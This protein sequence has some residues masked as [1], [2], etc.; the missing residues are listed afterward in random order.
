MN[1]LVCINNKL[2][3]LYSEYVSE[4]LIDEIN[5]HNIGKIFKF[6]SINIKSNLNNDIVVLFLIN[7]NKYSVS[8]SVLGHSF[9][10][11]F[12][13]KPFEIATSINEALNN[14]TIT[15]LCESGEIT[16]IFYDIVFHTMIA[17]SIKLFY[18]EHHKRITSISPTG[19]RIVENGFDIGFVTEC[20]CEGQKATLITYHDKITLNVDYNSE[21]GH[22]RT[23]C[24]S[25]LRATVGEKLLLDNDLNT[26]SI[27]SDRYEMV[28]CDPLGYVWKDELCLKTYIM[29]T[30]CGKIII[31]VISNTHTH[32]RVIM[33]DIFNYSAKR[34]YDRN[35]ASNSFLVIKNN[36]GVH[37]VEKISGDSM[38]SISVELIRINPISVILDGENLHQ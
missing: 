13:D 1:S 14:M 25:T 11:D 32:R 35:I 36:G 28:K 21:R 38:I 31:V 19:T 15:I 8:I 4:Q 6:Y 10:I 30:K 3:Q 17:K 7:G 12:S 2:I 34:S 22:I 9:I 24:I 29:L 33:E 18:N 26:I 5:Q 16:T 23:S 27:S 20:I 37:I